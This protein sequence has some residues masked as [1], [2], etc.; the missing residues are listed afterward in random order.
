MM[1]MHLTAGVE[2]IKKTY[3]T[4]SSQW[5]NHWISSFPDPST[6]FWEKGKP[7]LP[8]NLYIYKHYQTKYNFKSLS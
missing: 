1:Q 7:M 3:I 5:N 6:N 2:A 8:P 4:E